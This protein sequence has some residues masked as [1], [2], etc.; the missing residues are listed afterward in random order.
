MNTVEGST[1]QKAEPQINGQK[2]N[3]PFLPL[4]LIGGIGSVNS[5][6]WPHISL[7]NLET[8]VLVKCYICTI[9]SI[10][11]NILASYKYFSW[12]KMQHLLKTNS[13]IKSNMPLLKWRERECMFI[14]SPRNKSLFY[15]SD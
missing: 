8:T 7:Q 4:S 15:R 9:F 5:I 13:S 6:L 12:S 10:I 14:P 3:P 11:T 1:V 2:N